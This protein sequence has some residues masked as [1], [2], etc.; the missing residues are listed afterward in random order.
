MQKKDLLILVTISII[1]L[2]VFAGVIWILKSKGDIDRDKIEN[3]NNI[4][5]IEETYLE[6]LNESIVIR[7]FSSPTVSTNGQ[8][9]VTLNVFVLDGETFYAVEEY[10]PEGWVIISDGGGT[11]GNANKLAWVAFGSIN[12][13]PNTIIT[14]TVQAPSSAG[15]YNFDGIYLFEGMSSEITTQ[16]QTT[17]NVA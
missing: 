16:G 15:N 5:N 6:N 14:Y 17:V 13:G 3:N 1:I 8:I 7:S 9:D 11:T 10:I 2:L 12:L 4:K